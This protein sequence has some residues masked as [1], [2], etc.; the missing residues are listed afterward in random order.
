MKTSTIISIAANAYY[1]RGRLLLPHCLAVCCAP[2][3]II[4]QAD[5]WDWSIT[6]DAWLIGARFSTTVDI[7]DDGGQKF[8]DIGE[9][10]D[11]A[12]QLHLEGQGE[13]LGIL[14]DITS[15]Q[16]SD[17]GPKNDYVI[18]TDSKTTLLE[19]AATWS[20][21]QGPDSETILFLGTRLQLQ[22]LRELK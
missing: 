3:T 20:L 18:R 6:P 15:L 7:P 8:S 12:G 11:F 22:V 2:V 14:L 19:A 4:A 16:L 21:Q 9:N 5:D 10:L 17:S 13:R 1:R